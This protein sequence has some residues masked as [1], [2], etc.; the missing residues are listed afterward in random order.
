ME[1]QIQEI[2]H[3]TICLQ[4]GFQACKVIANQLE[5]QVNILYHNQDL[6]KV[7]ELDLV[8]NEF[9]IYKSKYLSSK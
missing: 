3:L 5:L 6:L 2:Q 7:K 4:M 1:L 8:D 9:N